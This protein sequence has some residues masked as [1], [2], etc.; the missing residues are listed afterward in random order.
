MRDKAFY[1]SKTFDYT[2]RLKVI[3]VVDYGDFDRTFTTSFNSSWRPFFLGG[4]CMMVRSG[5]MPICFFVFCFF[6]YFFIGL[7][8][9]HAKIMFA[10]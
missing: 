4:T 3:C 8:P 7:R 6:F 1:R 10:L 5:L 9:G 2:C